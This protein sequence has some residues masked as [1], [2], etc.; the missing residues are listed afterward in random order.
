MYGY[1]RRVSDA[2]FAELDDYYVDRTAEEGQDRLFQ[3]DK[4]WQAVWFLLRRAG[5]PLDVLIGN[6]PLGDPELELLWH[7]T[8]AQVREGAR[9]LATMPPEQLAEF[10]DA[11]LLARENVYPDVWLRDDQDNLRWVM[12]WYKGL[13]E[14]FAEAAEAGDGL[15]VA[16]EV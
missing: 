7:L 12:H 11:E 4:G 14:F 13:P 6:I 5:A 1:Y 8:P 16:V 2:E 15:I 9:Y 3:L 10:Y